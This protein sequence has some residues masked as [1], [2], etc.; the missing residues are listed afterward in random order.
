MLYPTV[1]EW[2]G[3]VNFCRQSIEMSSCSMKRGGGSGGQPLSWV[4]PTAPEPAAPAGSDLLGV[5]GNIVRPRIGGF[6]P[7]LYGGVAQNGN[8]LIVPAVA[9]AKRLLDSRKTRKASRGGGKMNDY[10]IDFEKAKRNL[11]VYI[12]EGQKGAPAKNIQALVAV[13]RGTS[14]KFRSEAEMIANFRERIGQRGAPKAKRVR[15]VKAARPIAS[16]PGDLP[17][18]TRQEEW[19]AYKALATAHL[20]NV[21]EAPRQANILKLAGILREGEEPDEYLAELRQRVQKAVKVAKTPKTPGKRALWTQQKEQAKR[22]LEELLTSPQRKEI[23]ALAKILQSGQDP[24]SYLATVGAPKR[25]ETTRKVARKTVAP[26]PVEKPNGRKIWGQTLRTA[27]AKLEGRV[28]KPKRE[29]ILELARTMK[30]KG[31]VSALLSEI[32][33][34]SNYQSSSSLPG[35]STFVSFKEPSRRPTAAAPAIPARVAPVIGKY[36]K[37]VRI[38]NTPEVKLIS[39]RPSAPAINLTQLKKK[40]AAE[41]EQRV[42]A[43]M[44]QYSDAE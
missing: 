5:H 1:R 30:A 42:A 17:R 37:G 27:R 34:R 32:A 2:L 33:A 38:R 43:K 28:N 29:N 35:A 41:R 26:V 18:M 22:Q 24:A 8:L 23:L 19:Q 20:K 10:R 21:T 4:D 11:K 15:T 36:P 39:P 7:S 31:N 40:M 12:P 3:T 6:L 44:A 25:K 13:R 14:K 9:A 16:E